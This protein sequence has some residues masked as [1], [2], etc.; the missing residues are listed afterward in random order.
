MPC[1]W[2]LATAGLQHLDL[3]RCLLTQ[4]DFWLMG[5]KFP[6]LTSLHLENVEFL[7]NACWPG[8]DHHSMECLAASNWPHVAQ[9]NLSCAKLSPI[10]STRWLKQ[11]GHSSHG[12]NWVA[13]PLICMHCQKPALCGTP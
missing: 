12:Y 8:A 9:T 2:A 1:R 7:G 11:I 4:D 10:T 13:R 3:T 6:S 5:L